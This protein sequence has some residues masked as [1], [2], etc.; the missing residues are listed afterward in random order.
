MAS[1]QTEETTSSL[2]ILFK[3]MY[4]LEK[5]KDLFG[6]S[7]SLGPKGTPLFKYTPMPNTVLDYLKSS[8]LRSS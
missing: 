4:L 5:L 1:I 7:I 8:P 2:I 3:D 6:G